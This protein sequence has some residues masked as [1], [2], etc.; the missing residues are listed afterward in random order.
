MYTG[1]ERL[2]SEL[3]SVALVYLASEALDKD[4][5][6][7]SMLESGDLGAA[8]GVQCPPDDWIVLVDYWLDL[9]RKDWPEWVA[10]E[11]ELEGLKMEGKSCAVVRGLDAGPMMGTWRENYIHARAQGL[12]MRY[13]VDKH[14]PW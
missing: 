2:D 4:G 12:A 5:K 1:R 10:V 9:T 14:K 3:Q 13:L 11:D 8:D 6:L 7:L